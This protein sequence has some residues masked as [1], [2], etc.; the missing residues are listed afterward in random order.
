[1]RKTIVILKAGMDETFLCLRRRQKTPPQPLPEQNRSGEGLFGSL[2]FTW[3]GRL[4]V[5]CL[6]LF[7]GK[8]GWLVSANLNG[9][10]LPIHNCG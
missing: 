7:E 3:H 8:R 2:L 5:V 4:A 1:M 10:P 9:E 6:P